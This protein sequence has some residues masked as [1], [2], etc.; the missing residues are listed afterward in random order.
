MTPN[1]TWSSTIFEKQDIWLSIL[2]TDALAAP[3][4]VTHDIWSICF[5]WLK[6]RALHEY[7]TEPTGALFLSAV[8]VVFFLHIIISH[9]QKRAPV[10]E[11]GD[12]RHLAAFPLRAGGQS[13]ESYRQWPY[14]RAN[15]GADDTTWAPDAS[16]LSGCG[17]QTCLPTRL[18]PSIKIAPCFRFNK[19]HMCD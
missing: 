3:L 6:N 17:A 5:N 9:I 16:F 19:R 12:V 1:V 18:M 13:A 7:Y 4:M 11:T 15:G 8:S 14:W 10:C 2:V